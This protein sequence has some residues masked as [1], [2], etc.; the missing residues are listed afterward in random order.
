VKSGWEWE[1][2]WG[3]VY[4]EETDSHDPPLLPQRSGGYPVRAVIHTIAVHLREGS[5]APKLANAASCLPK[6]IQYDQETGRA[7]LTFSFGNDKGKA[8]EAA[9][10][11]AAWFRETGAA[12]MLFIHSSLTFEPKIESL[13][14]NWKKN[15]PPTRLRVLPGGKKVR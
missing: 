15:L 7:D 2:P 5:L 14:S 4:T 8:Q 3:A 1:A 10:A 13:P 9:R 11:I 6:T 12:G